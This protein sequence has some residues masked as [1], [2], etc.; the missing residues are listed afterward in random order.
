[1]WSCPSAAEWL[2]GHGHMDMVTRDDPKLDKRAVS[3]L[4]KSGE[5]VPGVALEKRISLQVR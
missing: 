2:E 4:V 1:M 5:A 3:L